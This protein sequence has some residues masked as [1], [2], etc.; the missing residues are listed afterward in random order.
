MKRAGLHSGGSGGPGG[1][2]PGGPGSN[3]SGSGPA[4]SSSSQDTM[5]YGSEMKTRTGAGIGSGNF[6]NSLPSGFGSDT[7]NAVDGSSFGT[8]S[9]DLFDGNTGNQFGG[10]SGNGFRGGRASSFNPGSISQLSGDVSRGLAAGGHTNAASVLGALPSANQLLRGGLN[11]PVNS[12]LGNFRLSY[13]PPFSLNNNFQFKDASG[14]GSPSAVYESP[15]ARSGHVDFSASA[16]VGV[17]SAMEMNGPGGGQNGIGG[18]TPGHP[19][20]SSDPSSSV[21]LKLSF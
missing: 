2:R 8:G 12:S 21:T 13:Q 9:T 7:G 3:G 16:K 18:H 17:G 15:H 4:F 20:N 10:T 5:H 19:G 6:D 11:L 14:F 1:N